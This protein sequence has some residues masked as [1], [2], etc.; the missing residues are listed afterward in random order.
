MKS[1]RN[2]AWRL[3]CVLALLVAASQAEVV[4]RT[5]AVVNNHLV[6]WS[7]LDEQMR[8][9][10]LEN[11]RAL[12]DLGEGDRRA[13]F[14]HLVQ[15]RI[16]RDQM[17]GTLPAQAYE[18]DARI[19]EVRAGWQMDKDDA[20]WAATL[21]RYGL[22]AVELRGMVTNQIEILK[23]MEFRVRPMVRVTR[24]EVDDYYS[25]TLVPQVVA[26]GQTP[27]PL[28]EVTGKIRELLAEQKMNL[29]IEKWLAT[30]RAQASVQVLWDGVR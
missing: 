15:Y 25:L 20:K 13:A 10:A 2:L 22:S 28:E 23:F 1:R 11:M 19:A 18:V 12:K 29:E 27:E 30:L 3:L 14:E 4:D 5:I 9:E 8:F 16:L 17:Q 21:T 7:D 24:Q 6:T 26:K